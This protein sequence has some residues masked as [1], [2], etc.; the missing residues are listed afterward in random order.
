MP[1]P[2]QP[3]TG[4]RGRFPFRVFTG[5]RDRGALR[6]FRDL[7]GPEGQGDALAVYG[8]EDDGRQDEEELPAAALEWFC[9]PF[10]LCPE[11]D[12]DLP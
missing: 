1:R 6:P 11:P 4:R 2:R 8:A 3:F 12:P 5:S 9:P 7:R 10:A